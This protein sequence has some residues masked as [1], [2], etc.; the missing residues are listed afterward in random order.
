MLSCSPERNPHKLPTVIMIH[1]GIKGVWGEGGVAFIL[2]DQ[3]SLNLKMIYNNL[4]GA[5]PFY[6]TEACSHV[7]Y[8]GG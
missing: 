8:S 3:I 2:Q 5:V 7:E 1:A 4:K 6:T